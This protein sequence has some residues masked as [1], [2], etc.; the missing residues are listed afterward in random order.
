MNIVARPTDSTQPASARH[1]MAVPASHP[2]GADDPC[3]AALDEAIAHVD[4]AAGATLLL[5]A[6]TDEGVPLGATDFERVLSPLRR[7]RSEV[8]GVRDQL[9]EAE[10]EP[11]EQRPSGV[12]LPSEPEMER[13]AAEIVKAARR[14]VLRALVQTQDALAEA[15]DQGT[16]LGA[17]RQ[18]ARTLRH[19]VREL[20]VI[21]SEIV[22]AVEAAG[23]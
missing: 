16:D 18:I 14:R 23:R 11:V 22:D 2:D 8:Q 9:S 10:V 13:L 7:L 3:V 21:P 6:W 5:A 1:L 12:R 20:D 15:E 17:L 4:E 19:A